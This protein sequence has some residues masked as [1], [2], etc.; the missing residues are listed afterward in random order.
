VTYYLPDEKENWDVEDSILRE[1]ELPDRK[2]K[3]EQQEDDKPVEEG[4]E[5]KPPRWDPV[6]ISQIKSE[7]QAPIQKTEKLQA[8][9]LGVSKMALEQLIEVRYFLAN[10]CVVD[11]DWI[12]IQWGPWIQTDPDSINPDPQ[13]CL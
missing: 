6:H 3:R 13:N 7:L 2:R 10:S 4:E 8:A 12:L 11:L 5:G 9:G 1:E